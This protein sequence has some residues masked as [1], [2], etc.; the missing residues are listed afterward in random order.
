MK[1]IT[2]LFVFISIFT[3][4]NKSEFIGTYHDYFGS[5]IVFNNDFTYYENSWQVCTVTSWT[6]GKWKREND[7]VFI[8][9][10][11]VYDSLSY[12]DSTRSIKIDTLVL[13]YDEVANRITLKD[14]KEGVL[15]TESLGFQNDYQ[16]P[17]KLLIK[18]KR[19]YHILTNGKI[20]KTKK[21]AFSQDEYKP[22]YYFKDGTVKKY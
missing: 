3:T 19:L 9:P 7:T 11:F 5:T 12:Y 20:D 2:I 15:T 21:V 4:S 10:T 13:S 14:Y 18:G 8:T 6:I 17:F 1:L 16:N 22:T